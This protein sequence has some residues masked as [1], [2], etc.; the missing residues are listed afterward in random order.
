MPT[1]GDG[2]LDIRNAAYESWDVASETG[3]AGSETTGVGLASVHD[4][5]MGFWQT[6]W[7]VK[8]GA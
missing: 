8:S 7:A 3:N 1:A 2:T 5:G 6:D 4:S